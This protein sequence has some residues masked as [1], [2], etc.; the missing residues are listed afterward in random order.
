MP[1][2]AGGDPAPPA[3]LPVPGQGPRGAAAAGGRPHRGPRDPA[4]GT[5]DGG[6]G[7]RGSGC[8]PLAPGA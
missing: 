3:G 8:G 4:A 6:E 5:N 2:E 1:A 7:I